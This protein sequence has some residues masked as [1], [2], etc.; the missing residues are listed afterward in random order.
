MKKQT[1]IIYIH[2]LFCL[3]LHQCFAGWCYSKQF[4]GSMAIVNAKVLR[5]QAANTGA[6]SANT[7]SV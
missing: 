6:E 1:I 3:L 4:I 7:A 2:L 5:Q